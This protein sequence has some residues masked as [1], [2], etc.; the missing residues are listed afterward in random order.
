MSLNGTALNDMLKQCFFFRLK[1][2]E[3]SADYQKS[4]IKAIKIGFV[5][6]KHILEELISEV[7]SFKSIASQ[8][9]GH[10]N[11]KG[12]LDSISTMSV[13]TKS[14]I[15]TKQGFANQQKS[16]SQPKTETANYK[17]I[18]AKARLASQSPNRDVRSIASHANKINHISSK[19]NSSSIH[20]IENDQRL[21]TETIAYKMK[22]TEKFEIIDKELPNFD[23]KI[24]K[25]G[26]GFRKADISERIIGK[27]KADVDSTSVT[28]PKLNLRKGSSIKN[29]SDLNAQFSLMSTSSIK[30]AMTTIQPE[31]VKEPVTK[32][33][34]S[35]VS[36]NHEN[37]DKKELNTSK[38]QHDIIKN[39]KII[40][41]NEHDKLEIE[42]R[43]EAPSK[44]GTTN[45]YQP[46]E[47]S[48]EKLEEP[49]KTDIKSNAS[50]E[51]L[52]LTNA[53]PNQNADEN[54]K[55]NEVLETTE[56][57][58]P[59]LEI[60][61]INN[62]READAN[63]ISEMKQTLDPNQLNNVFYKRFSQYL[64]VRFNLNFS[65]LTPT[66]KLTQNIKSTKFPQTHLTSSQKTMRTNCS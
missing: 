43:S 58:E 51:S 39:S 21:L 22:K 11:I 7:I 29:G 24:E 25:I 49:I 27:L 34:L 38:V 3:T 32:L 47:K 62:N 6:T 28:T 50:I 48:S 31:K 65:A 57:I 37:K 40:L 56:V 4:C 42:L 1:K 17:P 46:T 26:L 23:T 13:S 5:D 20:A 55:S 8:K 10:L 35:S 18:A 15:T 2:L 30:T 16:K 19:N 44:P 14:I 45:Y 52:M 64:Q 41:D 54:L 59:K 9:A 60:S 66:V 12:K 53:C 36:N 63:Q 33:D 61:N